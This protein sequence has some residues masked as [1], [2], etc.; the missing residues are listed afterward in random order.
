MSFE[1]G[2][3]I[4]PCTQAGAEPSPTTAANSHAVETCSLAALLDWARPEDQ[5]VRWRWMQRFIAEMHWLPLIETLSGCNPR[6]DPVA[7]TAFM[8]QLDAMSVPRIAHLST[9]PIELYFWDSG[10]RSCLK[11]R[12]P[13]PKACAMV[14]TRFVNDR[15]RKSDVLFVGDDCVAAAEQVNPSCLQAL[16][17]LLYKAV[18]AV[19]GQLDDD[20]NHLML[21]GISGD[22]PSSAAYFQFIKQGKL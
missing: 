11:R 3:V 8:E 6:T 5:N 20:A 13:D 9:N 12:V 16:P 4:F 22:D 2:G 7:H 21:L 17:W 10:L 15:L 14:D 1:Y 18:T 19:K